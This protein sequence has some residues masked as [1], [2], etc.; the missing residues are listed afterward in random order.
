MSRRS[1]FGR[2]VGATD[3]LLA[4]SLLKPVNTLFAQVARP[5]YRVQFPPDLHGDTLRH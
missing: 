2:S 5:G 3:A 4:G 1:F